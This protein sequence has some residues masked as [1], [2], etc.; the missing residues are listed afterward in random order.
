LRG[1]GVT[2]AVAVGLGCFQSLL[3]RVTAEPWM[4]EPLR[5]GFDQGIPFLLIVVVLAVLGRSLPQRGSLSEGRASAAPVAR[6]NPVA[7]AA[8]A[9]IA[10]AVLLAGDRTLRLPLIVSLAMTAL[11]LSQVV[12]TG[13][14]GQISLAQFT[15]AGLAAYICARFGWLAFPFDAALAV[16]ITTVLGTL[17]GIPA[18]RIRG[19]QLAVVTLAFAITIEQLV[20]RNP[21]ISGP[22]T[23]SSVDPP[24]LFGVDLG[25]LGAGEYPQRLFGVVVLVT[26][27][28]LALAVVN[29]R[30]SS[31][32]RRLLAV[33]ANE[34]AAEA[35]GIDVSR[36]KLEAYALSSFLAA[37]AGAIIG[38]SYVT[39]DAQAFDSRFALSILALGFVGGIGRVSGAFVAGGLTAGGIVFALVSKLAGGEVSESQFLFTGVGLILVARF[40][41]DGLAGL[42]AGWA[43]RVAVAR[44]GPGDWPVDQPGV[45]FVD[46]SAESDPQGGTLPVR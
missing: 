11:M 41:P 40:V 45:V 24:V 42:V 46:P 23:V 33:R 9:V 15:L 37:V 35:S 26:V 13:F 7:L 32:G 10:L 1:F 14:V 43:R 44:A 27:S 18:L 21:E 28:A 20:Y 34:A 8:L 12:I 36:T 2:V 25:I 17:V 19:V 6:V 29:V 4:P 22:A 38:Y 30:R 5:G 3:V 16:V 31:F 39:F